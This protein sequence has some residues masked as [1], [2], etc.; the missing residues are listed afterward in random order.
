MY[1]Y[2]NVAITNCQL[3]LNRELISFIN[4]GF[5]SE[6]NTLAI[7]VQA[8][9]GALA[10]QWLERLQNAMQMASA[11]ELKKDKDPANVA[12]AWAQILTTYVQSVSS[13]CLESALTV[14]AYLPDSIAIEF[15]DYSLD[16]RMPKTQ[17]ADFLPEFDMPVLKTLKYSLDNWVKNPNSVELLAEDGDPVIKAWN[18]A[19]QNKQ[20]AMQRLAAFSY[21][22]GQLNSKLSQ[23]G[24]V[25]VAEADAVFDY[26]IRKVIWF[27]ESEMRFAMLLRGQ[28][29][30]ISRADMIT[31]TFGSNSSVIEYLYPDELS[32][33]RY[34]TAE[35][36]AFEK[37]ISD[38]AKS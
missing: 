31:T 26:F 9:Q 30:E 33:G 22:R 28:A 24:G 6:R 35:V 4:Q 23:Q 10:T 11:A 5:L 1:K 37:K 20:R 29:F 19:R 7:S 8:T 16:D 15:K 34:L 38:Y 3:K 2:S 18:I 13:S 27:R 21:L 25:L 32:P 14:E 36:E 12:D 17:V